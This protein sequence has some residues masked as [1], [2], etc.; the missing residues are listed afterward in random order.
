L[1]AVLLESFFIIDRA[2]K[3]ALRCNFHSNIEN[4]ISFELL[5]IQYMQ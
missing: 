2:V 1:L 4:N 3:S 5:K